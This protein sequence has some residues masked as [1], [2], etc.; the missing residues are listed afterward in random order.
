MLIGFLLAVSLALQT[1]PTTVPAKIGEFQGEYRFLSNFYPATVEFEGINYPTVEHAYQSAKTLDIAER[2][3]IAVLATPSDAK[4]EGR[5]L[6]LRDDWETAKFDVMERCVRYKFTRDADLRAKLL[7]TG[8]AV[9]E[10]GNN[11]GDQV[12]GVV[13]G[14]GENRLGKILMKLREELREK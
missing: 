6:K 11:W 5:K 13:N 2:K 14:V 7:A 10:E 9:L 12:W 1:H 8:Y 4:R 3:R